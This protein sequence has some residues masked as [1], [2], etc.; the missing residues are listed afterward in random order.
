ME[1][2]TLRLTDLF[3]AAQTEV[4]L[5]MMARGGFSSP[6]SVARAGLVHLARHLDLDVHP[7]LFDLPSR[8]L[9]PLKRPDG[10]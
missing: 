6:R 2:D 4:I 9:R 3:D 10:K 1:A 7:S 8:M 5:L